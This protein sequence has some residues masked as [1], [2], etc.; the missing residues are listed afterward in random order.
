MNELRA[1]SLL[2]KVVGWGVAASVIFAGWILA[3][4]EAPSSPGLPVASRFSW[5]S[6]DLRGRTIVM[7]AYV[8]I[9][10]TMWALASRRLAM[11]VAKDSPI[12]PH[13]KVVRRITL[14]VVALNVAFAIA[15]GV[16]GS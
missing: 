13:L 15:I 7:T 14:A 3:G 16:D 10:S 4:V 11:A 6:S 2:I 5:I 1:D 12:Y 8:V 9:A